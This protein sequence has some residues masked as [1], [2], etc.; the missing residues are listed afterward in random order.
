MTHTNH[1][2]NTRVWKMGDLVIHDDDAKRPDMLMRVLG[3]IASGP[4]RGKFRTQ[5]FYPEHQPKAWRRKIW[6]NPLEKLHDPARFGIDT[7]RRPADRFSRDVA[8]GD[9][10][11]KLQIVAACAISPYQEAIDWIEQHRGS[12]SAG[13]LARLIL[14]LWNSEACFSF[15]ECIDSLDD[16]RTSIAV[17]CV[18]KFARE[19]ETDELVRAGYRVHA[20]FP[21]LWDIGQAGTEAKRATRDSL[22]RNRS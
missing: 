8:R 6:V 5:Y 20:M 2:A 4:N 7:T 13:R 17:R 22:E 12:G 19:G 3:Q 14:S 9:G 16:A 21:L 15:R 11:P 10:R 18:E 1:D